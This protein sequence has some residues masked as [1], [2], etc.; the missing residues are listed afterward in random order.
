MKPRVTVSGLRQNPDVVEQ[1][2]ELVFDVERQTS[3]ACTPAAGKD[4][5]LLLIAKMHEGN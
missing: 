2:M 1:A 5:A 4:L 3:N